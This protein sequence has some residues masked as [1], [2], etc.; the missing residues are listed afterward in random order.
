MHGK[1]IGRKGEARYSCSTRAKRHGCD[2][3]LAP[4]DPIEEQIAT[5][6]AEFKPSAKIR[7]EIL[8]RLAE[9]DETGDEETR[10]RRRQLNER[11]KRLRDLFEMGDLDKAEYVSKRDAIDTELDGLAPGPTADLDGARA[12]LEDFGRFWEDETDPQIRR[13]LLAQLFE[14]VWVD[15][16]KIVAVR[17]TPAFVALFTALKTTKPPSRGRRC[18]KGGSDGTRT[19]DLRRDRPAL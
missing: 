14:R 5:F 15:A 18:A 11:R 6:V 13:E 19:R 7:D 16:K 17:P 10:R 3:P 1:T 9:G 12:V 2:Q 8:R 4:A